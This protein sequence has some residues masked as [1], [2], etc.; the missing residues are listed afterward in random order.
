MK[1][2]YC[3]LCFL[4]LLSLLMNY[5]MFVLTMLSLNSLVYRVGMKLILSVKTLILAVQAFSA[6]ICTLGSLYLYICSCSYAQ[7]YFPIYFLSD[8]MSLG[9]QRRPYDFSFCHSVPFEVQ[10]Y[11]HF[12]T[13]EHVCVCVSVCLCL[14]VCWMVPQ[15][16][17]MKKGSRPNKAFDR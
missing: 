15:F 4:F 3:I 11:L 8:S 9:W 7:S 2:I 12:L 16:R 17:I 10:K 6:T 13:F 14:C 1:Y 5:S